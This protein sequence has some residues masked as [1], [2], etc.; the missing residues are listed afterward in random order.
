MKAGLRICISNKFLGNTVAAV[1]GT[2]SG[3]KSSPGSL[4]TQWLGIKLSDFRKEVEVATARLPGR[5]L[6]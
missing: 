1:Q 4:G 6:C 5:L 3:A 2:V